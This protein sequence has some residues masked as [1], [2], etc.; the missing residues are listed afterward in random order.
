[1]K[2]TWKDVIAFSNARNNDKVKAFI[3]GLGYRPI[4]WFAKLSIK[5]RP[6]GLYDSNEEV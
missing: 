6:S 2:D 5:M 3:V 1:M 4:I